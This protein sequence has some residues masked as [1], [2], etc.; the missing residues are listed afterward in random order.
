MNSERSRSMK[1]GPG[2]GLRLA[3]IALGFDS[4]KLVA[5]PPSGGIIV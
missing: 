4:T 1:E 2:S 3:L 5:E